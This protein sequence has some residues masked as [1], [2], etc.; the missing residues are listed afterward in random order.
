MTMSNSSLAKLTPEQQEVVKCDF[1]DILLVNAY[2][3]TG[4]TSTL[5]QFCKARSEYNILYLSYN[6][7]MRKEAEEKFKELKNVSVKTMHSLAYETL[8]MSDYKTRLGNLRAL[9]ITHLFS[10][11]NA[12]YKNMYAN[13]A[14]KLIRKFCNS[15]FDM[16]GFIKDF[17]SNPKDYSLNDNMRK[18]MKT[19]IKELWNKIKTNAEFAYEHDFYLKE[20]QLS[21]PKLDYDFILVDEAQDINP[22]VIDIV[23][24]QQH[25]KKVFIG[26][27]Y[28]SI[29]KF[30]GAE[31]SLSFLSKK[32]NSKTLYLTQSFRC[33]QAISNIANN[34]LKL[35]NA[36]RD[37]KGTLKT[38][39][40][41]TNQKTII[42]RTNAILFDF[43]IENIDKKMYFVGG[44]DSYS[45][46]E[47]LDIQ[48]IVFKK[49]DFIKNKFYLNF[50]D[51]KELSSY[52]TEAEEIDLKQKINILFK[53]IQSDII[54]LIKKIKS[55]SVKKESQADLILTTGHKSKGLE[56]DNVEILDD[57]INIREKLLESEN[58]ELQR[59]EIHL[60]YVALTRTKGKLSM[61][62]DFIIK[63]NEV[64]VIQERLEI[65]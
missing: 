2:A 1:E 9:D 38:Q 32:E 58:F 31:N 13:T 24:N 35:L 5:V 8:E 64:K 50:Q 30:R 55:Q 48:N 7:S 3:G 60:F 27:T 49:F 21:K 41:N 52:A 25:A 37:F 26:D 39:Q 44:I 12:D 36:P 59:E 34:Y 63:D 54:S 16:E 57:F 45:F 4:K 53:Y 62:E 51:L 65:K 56:W 23:L 42:A 6:S 17:Y 43:A 15:S 11:L 61:N 40:I 33:P 47:L 28:Q 10:D 20:Y 18:Y 22:C 19:F 14:L 46:D 29:Y